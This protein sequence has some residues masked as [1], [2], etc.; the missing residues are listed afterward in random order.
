ME[1]FPRLRLHELKRLWGSKLQIVSRREAIEFKNE[2]VAVWCKTQHD[3][4]DYLRKND[5]PAYL[6]T[7]MDPNA[8]RGAAP[9]VIV[10]VGYSWSNDVDFIMTNLMPIL[11]NA[12]R[13]WY[14]VP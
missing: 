14:Y 3:A 8:R 4:D 2:V 6:F 1:R 12:K 5:K 11:A 9:E 13:V 10:T 7:G